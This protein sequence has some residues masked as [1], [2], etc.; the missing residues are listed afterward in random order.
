MLYA[1]VHLFFPSSA[2]SDPF[3]SV[4]ASVGDWA[5]VSFLTRALLC[6]AGFEAAERALHG[7][8]RPTDGGELHQSQFDRTGVAAHQVKNTLKLFLLLLLLRHLCHLLLTCSTPSELWN[9]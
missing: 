7:R 5:S 1:S 8:Q 4:F 2:V 9:L 3:P 6:P